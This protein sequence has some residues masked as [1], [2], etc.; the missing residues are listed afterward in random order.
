MEDRAVAR[1]GRG[2]PGRVG[3][4]GLLL[5]LVAGLLTGSAGAAGAQVAPVDVTGTLTL[6]SSGEPVPGASLELTVPAEGGGRATAAY[7]TTDAQ[8]GYSVQVPVGR[9]DVL[10]TP[11]DRP[12]GPQVELEA[13]VTGPGVVDLVLD[14]TAT[15]LAGRVTGDGAP[16]A[17]T[18][19][20]QVK[21]PTP[22]LATVASVRTDAQGAY[23]FPAYAGTGDGSFYVSVSP[24]DRDRWAAEY[25]QDAAEWQAADLVAVPRSE[26][27]DFAL[28]APAATDNTIRGQVTADGTG[29][30]SFVRLYRAD[31]E[32]VAREVA[33]GSFRP[34]DGAGRYEV[35]AL[36]P[37][38][39]YVQA[40][41]Q[42]DGGGELLPAFHLDAAALSDARA[43][44]LAGG[45]DAVADVH[46]R[47][48][49]V[50]GGLVTGPAGE[51]LAG[52]SVTLEGR[53]PGS[54]QMFEGGTTTTAADGRWQLRARTDL[55]YRVS[56]ALEGYP[57][58]WY[59]GASREEDARWVRADGTPVDAR[60]ERSTGTQPPPPWW[61]ELC[62]APWAG[63]PWLRALVRW[64]CGVQAQVPAPRR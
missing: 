35:T 11:P 61:Q 6:A 23:R 30:P 54:G 4:V 31:A 40:A 53:A 63:P 51:P 7:T 29:V 21:G 16:V 50:M 27:L 60:L 44:Q 1:A 57:T 42:D 47:R 46:L 48:A 15:L 22:G 45:T 17:A 12:F 9:Y 13:V 55:E 20:L 36:P 5:A 59:D 38:T 34:T 10:V 14:D 18:V 52:V 32:G 19:A 62:T 2:R 26:P 43:V 28:A 3:V 24:D 56:F 39:Y 41:P 8:G 58:Q 33:P 25:H 49:P 37:G 64:V